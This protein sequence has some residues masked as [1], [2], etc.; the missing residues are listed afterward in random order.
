MKNKTLLTLCAASMLLS[1]NAMAQ[2]PFELIGELLVPKELDKK[3]EAPEDY[4]SA[5]FTYTNNGSGNEYYFTI[6]DNCT[7]KDAFNNRF[8]YG[9][10][11]PIGPVKSITYNRTFTENTP[12]TIVLPFELPAGTV[13]NADFY[14]LDY[15]I[16]DFRNGNRTW[17][18]KMKKISGLPQVNKPYAIIP[19]GNALTID[20]GDNSA[21]FNPTNTPDNYKVTNSKYDYSEN[22]L[23]LD[24]NPNDNAE[25]WYFI[26]T[27]GYK[28]WQNNDGE[29][30]RCYGFEGSTDGVVA[31]GEFGKV[32]EGTIGNALHAYLCK[33]DETVQ[34]P[35]GAAL[36]KQNGGAAK[37]ASV[38][39]LP[40]TIN[41]EFVDT[42]A[43]GKEHTTYVGKFNRI[44]N[45][46]LNRERSTFDLKGRNVDGKKTAKGVYLK[47]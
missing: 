8:S 13:I 23:H 22:E 27:S 29:T 46:R 41:V 19:Q 31:K 16:P 43:S 18:A 11:S 15:V 35:S 12:S 32:A 24:Y 34:L 38:F 45:V 6:N 39:S 37:S 4:G 2:K 21:T 47:K 25:D 10:H 40:E 33:K 26:G 36:I 30:G 42:D 9:Q 14:S 44:D 7:S 5:S 20:L 28:V 1:V 17:L 3:G